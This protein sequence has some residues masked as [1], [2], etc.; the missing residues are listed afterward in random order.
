MALAELK[1]LKV[2][3]K[4]LL[5]TSFIQP[6]IFPLGASVLFVKKKDG[7]LRRR[8]DYQQLNKVTIK[9]KYPILRIDDLFD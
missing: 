9:N 7:S 8:V 3:I 4:D 6:S 2:Q 5:E 1:E